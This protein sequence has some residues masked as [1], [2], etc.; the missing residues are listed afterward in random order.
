MSCQDEFR[1]III[2]RGEGEPT[3]PVSDDHQNG[4]WIDTDLYEGEFYE[5][6]LTGIVYYRSE[7]GIET[8]YDPSM[9]AGTNIY[10]S[11]GTINVERIVTIDPTTG[12]LVFDSSAGGIP[13]SVTPTW[14]PTGYSDVYGMVGISPSGTGIYGFSDVG[15]GV[16]GQ[17]NGTGVVA[18][19]NSGLALLAQGAQ[20]SQ[21]RGGAIV[22]TGSATKDTNA[23]LDLTST[24]QGFLQVR[25]TTAQRTTL[26]GLMTAT[27]NGMTVFDTTTSSVWVWVSPDWIEQ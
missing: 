21:L 23:V 17:S 2:K 20:G 7:N 26:G 18:Q 3:I 12:A 15:E 11:D 8:V 5:D 24:T 27:Q 22:S 25:Q 6:I 9:P 13:F 14:G 16:R 19:S 4:D 1:R 10:N